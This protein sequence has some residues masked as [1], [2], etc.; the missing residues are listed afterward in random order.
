MDAH[1]SDNKM[2]ALD[3]YFRGVDAEKGGKVCPDSTKK[4]LPNLLPL[5]FVGGCLKVWPELLNITRKSLLA[6][7]PNLK[8]SLGSKCFRL[9]VVFFLLYVCLLQRKTTRILF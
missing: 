1:F 4:L 2:T 8:A 7:V 3:S 9:W 5:F 6:I